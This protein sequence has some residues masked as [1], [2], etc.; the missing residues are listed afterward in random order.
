M[1][2]DTEGR[3]P[4][5]KGR[6]HCPQNRWPMEPRGS[7]VATLYFLKDIASDDLNVEILECGKQNWS[8]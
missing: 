1:R 5:L 2:V 3:Y 6:A 8:K 7:G 4:D